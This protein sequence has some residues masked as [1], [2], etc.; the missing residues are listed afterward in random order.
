MEEAR[1]IIINCSQ[2]SKFITKNEFMYIIKQAKKPDEITGPAL[3]VE[4][5]DIDG[6]FKPQ[7]NYESNITPITPYD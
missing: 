5:H 2:S 7:P 4:E 6:P 1:N 3:Q